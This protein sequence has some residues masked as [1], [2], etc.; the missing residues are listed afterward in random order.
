MSRTCGIRFR[1][2][3]SAVN[4]QAASAGSAEFLEPLAAISPERGT[5]PSITS[6]SNLLQCLPDPAVRFLQQLLRLVPRYLLLLHDDGDSDTAP[7]P[8]QEFGRLGIGHTGGLL[9]DAAG[10]ILQ[11]L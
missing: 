5:P 1:V 7:R 2:T 3:G 11:F 4:R 8:I 6:L 10:T 9:N